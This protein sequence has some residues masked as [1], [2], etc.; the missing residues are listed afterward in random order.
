MAKLEQSSPND[1][2]RTVL[3]STAKL[4][5]PFWAKLIWQSK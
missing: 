4:V 3:A 1:Q 2:A 5:L